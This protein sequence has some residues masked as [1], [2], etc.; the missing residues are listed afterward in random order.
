MLWIIGLAIILLLFVWPNFWVRSVLTKY[1]EPRDDI[2]GTGGELAEHLKKVLDLDI[3]IKITTQGDHF[4]PASQSVCLT[5]N[6]FNGKHLTAVATAAHEIGH[7]IQWQVGD[8]GLKRRGQW[9]GYSI[10]IQR[11][12]QFSL[13]LIPILHLI[14]GGALF[15]RLLFIP[16]LL[17]VF[18]NTLVH[19]ITLPVEWDASFNKALPILIKGN[20]VNT[21]D[22]KSIKTILRA[23]ALTYISSAAVSLLNLANLVRIF[24]RG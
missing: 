19:L 12:A 9:A 1:A 22:V 15:G 7:A 21:N 2:S 11:M 24:R 8:A 18:F 4:D 16:V 17:S 14:P 3:E 10:L 23:C 6:N 20:Y 5:E 13:V